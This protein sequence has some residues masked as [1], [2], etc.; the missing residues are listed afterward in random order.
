[1]LILGWLVGSE[2][3]G[4]A[5]DTAKSRRER[6]PWNGFAVGSWIVQSETLTMDGK[7]ETSREKRRRI[8]D[9][10]GRIQLERSKD[11]KGTSTMTHVPGYLP[12]NDENLKL[13]GNNIEELIMDGSKYRCEVKKYEG[14]LDKSTLVLTYWHCDKIS[15]PFRELRIYALPLAL[16]SDIVRVETSFESPKVKEK[17][18]YQVMSLKDRRK[19]GD[20]AIVCVREEGQMSLDT[21]D[22]KFEGRLTGW[23]SN[24]VP[25]RQAAM[26]TEGTVNDK[27]MKR[28]IEIV[29]FE[30]VKAK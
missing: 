17:T 27:K 3:T 5:Q 29:D 2:S 13:I 14:K 19:I 12:E 28:V 15:V 26:I 24:E 18:K 7:T 9:L 16:T 1:M 30:V 23:L 21:E 20:K 25:G 6:D 10:D 8:D 22:E 11:G 4:G